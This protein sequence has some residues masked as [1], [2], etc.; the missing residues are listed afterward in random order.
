MLG[1]GSGDYKGVARGIFFFFVVVEQYCILIMAV[2]IQP[3]KISVLGSESQLKPVLVWDF[4]G[5]LVVKTL[6]FHCRGWCLVGELRSG[7]Q[8]T[9]KQNKNSSCLQWAHSPQANFFFVSLTYAIHSLKAE[10]SLS[11]CP[12]HEEQKTNNAWFRNIL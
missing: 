2:I 11:K 1:R 4:P 8:K 9:G 6:C 5:G 3:D 7:S 10:S 12:I